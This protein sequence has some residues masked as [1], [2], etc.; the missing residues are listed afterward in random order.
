MPS[1]TVKW[2]SDSK[3]F[4]F[5]QPDDG[6]VDL[7]V[8]FSA[9]QGHGFKT[10]T[11]GQRVSYDAMA[12]PIGWQA[13]VV[14]P[15]EDGEAGRERGI[16]HMADLHQGSLRRRHLIDSVDPERYPP[17]LEHWSSTPQSHEQLAL[18]ARFYDIDSPLES[19]SQNREDTQQRFDP[20]GLLFNEM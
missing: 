19:R 3:G 5:I 20:F 11:Q 2:F 6:G 4:G 14:Q 18:R 16:G 17:L 8:H 10:L 12:R 13:G 15:L 9:T 7:M 1:G